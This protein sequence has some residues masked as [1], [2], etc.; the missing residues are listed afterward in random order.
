VEPGDVAE[1]GDLGSCFLQFQGER[2]DGADEGRDV[3][4]ELGEF[5]V[6]AGDCLAELRVVARSRASSPLSAPRSRMRW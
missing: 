1:R 3:G 4:A 6:L 2:V 5:P